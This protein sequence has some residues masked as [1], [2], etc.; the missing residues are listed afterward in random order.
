MASLSRALVGHM[1]WLWRQ[2]EPGGRQWRKQGGRGGGSSLQPKP[3]HHL[4]PCC[5]PPGR[6]PSA[7]PSPRMSESKEQPRVQKPAS[8]GRQL[9]GEAASGV[10]QLGL[11]SCSGTVLHHQTSQH[12][13]SGPGGSRIR[14]RNGA[15]NKHKNKTC[16]Q[17]NTSRL[18]CRAQ[19]LRLRTTQ[20][21]WVGIL[22]TY[23]F[24]APVSSF[25]K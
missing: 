13:A 19:Q 14:W 1:R 11:F 4:G 9:P 21:Y 12:V 2:E 6:V 15:F 24:C 20:A 18:Y 16:D 22:M 25:V 17:E 7:S 10:L 5:R 23:T 8:V 3:Q